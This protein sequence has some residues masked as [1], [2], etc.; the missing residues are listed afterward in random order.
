MSPILWRLILNSH[1]N[2]KG[3]TLI[4]LL[5]V[6]IIVGVLAAVALP[7]LV[8]QVGKARET[9]MKNALGTV[10]RAQMAYHWEQQV[11]CCDS[12]TPDQILGALGTPIDSK[13]INSWTF[14]TSALATQITFNI[15]NN[16]WQ[17]DN[18]RGLSGGVF[19]DLSS[20][21]TYRSIICQSFNP[22]ATTDQPVTTDPFCGA[23]A[24]QLR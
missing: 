15:T 3:F 19:F 17:I 18:T 5:V 20:S 6:V 23:N 21:D 16:D 8:A 14:D 24:Y 2:K 12:A 1:N 4:E 9:E 13:Y 10:A 11:F 7:N 22:S